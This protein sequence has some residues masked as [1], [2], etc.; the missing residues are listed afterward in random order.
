MNAEA[1]E[2][3]RKI[4]AISRAAPGLAWTSG[5]VDRCQSNPIHRVAKNVITKNDVVNGTFRTLP[6][7]ILRSKE[8]GGALLR[9]GP[10][11]LEDIAFDKLAD[12]GFTFVQILGD[13]ERPEICGAQLPPGEGLEMMVTAHL[14]VRYIGGRCSAAPKNVLSCGFQE[15][16]D[17]LDRSR[18]GD[19]TNRRGIRSVARN[20][21]MDVRDVRVDYRNIG[22]G[23]KFDAF[24]I[25]SGWRSMD[26]A[27]IEDNMVVAGQHDEI[28]IATGRAIGP[29]IGNFQ[30]HQPVVI[31][32]RSAPMILSCFGFA[33]DPRHHIAG[34]GAVQSLDG[35]AARQLLRYRAWRERL[36]P[37]DQ[38]LGAA[39]NGDVVVR[40]AVLCTKVNPE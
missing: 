23:G 20:L 13:K 6:I 8:N 11:I 9:H 34:G 35:P 28:V 25:L 4:H 10:V 33:S 39:A 5:G 30:P 14:D 36:L 19:R 31:G 24:Y 16:V 15:I 7:L 38:T 32:A 18:A 37:A 21:G 40:I 26:P 1:V 22:A 12:A 2:A 3:T 29:S 17:D 27:A